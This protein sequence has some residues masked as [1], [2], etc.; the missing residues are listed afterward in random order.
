MWPLGLGLLIAGLFVLVIGGLLFLTFIL[1]PLAIIAAI[2]G[3][4]LLVAGFLALLVR[5]VMH[6]GYHSHEHHH[7]YSADVKYCSRCGAPNPKGN[8]YCSNCGQKF[9]EEPQKSI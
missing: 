1:I 4:I 8:L 2:I 9:V 3:V 5:G 7:P 6:V